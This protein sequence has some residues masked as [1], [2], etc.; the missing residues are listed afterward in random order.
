MPRAFE[1]GYVAF[2]GWYVKE[3]FCYCYDREKDIFYRLLSNIAICI[4]P[5]QI[6]TIKLLLPSHVSGAFIS[7]VSLVNLEVLIGQQYK[8][9]NWNF[10]MTGYLT[11]RPVS[12]KLSTPYAHPEQEVVPS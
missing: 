7:L 1:Q 8:M 2:F 5:S 9:S 11:A 4:Q 10:R 12:V 3:R 6:H